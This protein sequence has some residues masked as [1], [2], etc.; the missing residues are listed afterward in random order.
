M[1]DMHTTADEDTLR[2]FDIA[3]QASLLSIHCVAKPPH[4]GGTAFVGSKKVMNVTVYGALNQHSSRLEV[5]NGV[6]NS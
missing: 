4:L 1:A 3:V 2:F 5:K 6:R